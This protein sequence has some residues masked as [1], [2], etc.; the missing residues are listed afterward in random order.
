[1]LGAGGYDVAPNTDEEEQDG[2]RAA[3]GREPGARDNRRSLPG[4]KVFLEIEKDP[5]HFTE[6]SSSC[7]SLRS[8][9]ATGWPR[10]STYTQPLVGRCVTDKIAN[11]EI[12]NTRGRIM[13]AL[14]WF[15]AASGAA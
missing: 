11:H 9:C 2:D 6:A 12:R 14:T 8:G 1:M 15:R 10:S 7:M 13:L 4:A 5:I 3:A